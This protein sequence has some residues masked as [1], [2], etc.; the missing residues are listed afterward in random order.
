MAPKTK[1]KV[2]R[3]L[4]L[5]SGFAWT[6]SVFGVFLP[7]SSAVELLQGLGAKSIAYDP[8]LDYWLRMA[9]GAF[10]LVGLVY[11]ALAWNPRRWAIML[12][13]FGWIMVLEGMILLYHGWRL[14]LPPFPFTADVSA[15]LFAG[16]GILWLKNVASKPASES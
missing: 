1:L 5:F 3:W 4:L 16:I 14:H 7:W 9:S 13:F 6:V 10:T 12:P 8:M 15:C 11:F 2:L